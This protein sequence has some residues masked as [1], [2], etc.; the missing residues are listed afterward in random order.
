MGL[1]AA[2]AIARAYG[3]GKPS[4]WFDLPPDATQPEN[5]EDMVI[6]DALK[7]LGK[8]ARHEMIEYVKYKIAQSNAPHV[9]E[10]RAQYLDSLDRWLHRVDSD[11][12]EKG[13]QD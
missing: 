11:A 2:R 5:R 1:K 13:Q 8:D 6:A 10:R 4:D 9:Q 12:P 7:S 3:D